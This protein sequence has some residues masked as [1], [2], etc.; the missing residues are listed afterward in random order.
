MPLL[1]EVIGLGF[2]PPVGKQLVDDD[3]PYHQH[4][5]NLHVHELCQGRLGDT[6]GSVGTVK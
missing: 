3:A 4:K 2:V 1:V 5:S 6:L